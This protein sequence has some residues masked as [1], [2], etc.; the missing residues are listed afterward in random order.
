VSIDTGRAGGDETA[1]HRHDP[2]QLLGLGR[3]LRARPGRLA[4]D[5]DQIGALSSKPQAVVDADLGHRPPS[6]VGEGVRGDV[7]DAHHQAAVNRG[8]GADRMR[9]EHSH[10][11]TVATA[12]D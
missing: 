5:V 3:P 12:Y 1:H 8:K 6:A 2:C 11:H 10:A 9:T 7:D 4:S